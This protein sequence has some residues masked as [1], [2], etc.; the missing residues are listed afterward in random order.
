MDIEAGVDVNVFLESQKALM[1][2]DLKKMVLVMQDLWE[3][4]LWKQL[5][6][7]LM[8]FFENPE[9]EIFR[10]D[11]FKFFVIS[12]SQN[13]NKLKLVMLGLSASGQCESNIEAIK[14]L[15]SLL[16]NVNT[17]TTK[18]AYVYA[19]IEIARIKMLCGDLDSCYELLSK[20]SKILDELDSV[21]PIIYALFYRVN[22]D[23][24]KS[25][26]NYGLFYKNS[27][28]FLACNDFSSLSIHEQQQWA[29]DL[30]I[31]ALLGDTIY[32]FG[33]LLL[34]PI[35][36]TL[37]DTEH[38]WLR[39][40]LFAFNS[41]N[42]LKF[43]SL[44][45]HFLKHS[46]L[47]SSIPFLRQKI[48]LT[49]LIEAIFRRSPHDRILKFST[50]ADE[51]HLP[52]Y[53]IEH[54]V[55][56]AL[57]LDLIRGFI[58]QVDEIVRITW[59]HPRVLDRSQ[60][61]IMKKRI[62]DWHRS[63]HQLETFITDV[64][65]DIIENE[66]L[67]CNYRYFFILENLSKYMYGCD[68][69]WQ[70]LASSS[71]NSI[72]KAY[73]LAV[74]TIHFHKIF[75]GKC[76][77]SLYKIF[78]KCFVCHDVLKRSLL[79]LQCSHIGCW[80]K[81]HADVHA[82]NQNHNFAI[83]LYSGYLYCFSCHDFIYDQVFENIYI[84]VK[85]KLNISFLNIRNSIYLSNEELELSM[86]DQDYLDEDDPQVIC[87]GDG[88]RG[89]Q[90]MGAT[91]FMNV[92]IQCLV[93]NPIFRNYF[94]SDGHMVK[95]CLQDNCSCCAM[96]T[97][98]AEF[99][100]KK[101][102]SIPFGPSSFLEIMWKLSKELKGYAEQDAHE[103]FVCL[104]SQIHNHS[105]SKIDLTCNCV[106]HKTFSGILQSDVTCSSCGNITS[107][108]DP[109]MDVSLE[110]KIK[111]TVGAESSSSEHLVGS[112]QECLQRFTSPEK[113]SNNE[114]KCS[115]CLSIS[116]KAMK[117]LRFKRIPLVICFQL[118]RFEHSST[119]TKIDAHVDFSFQLD[120]F[121]YIAR[122][123]YVNYY[124]NDFIYD[125][126]CVVCHQGQI[127]TG[128][129]TSFARAND[130]WFQFDDTTILITNEK[131]VL[132]SN[133]YLLFYIRQNLSY[134]M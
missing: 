97:V 81:K 125:L 7:T 120:M 119:P 28:L 79:C 33:E 2:D 85:R 90:N 105:G 59:V 18:D 63:T 6:D 29:Y 112:L 15:S 91:C 77:K 98:I 88:L 36:D 126:L 54:L 89:I 3:R 41:G 68:H 22:A 128:H 104:M 103:F 50:I 25:K 84:L 10:M 99:F 20:S 86:E 39:Q 100:S 114:Y 110:L 5:T 34:H 57:S 1:K 46:L 30:S 53:E 129:Y 47:Q 43:E 35:L 124:K 37:S 67:V 133:A 27:L 56:K 109:I 21:D 102:F 12:F 44:M 38:E 93:H 69:V 8:E 75:K 65:S 122:N 117:Q 70:L 111:C 55:M 19:L 127:N 131:T 64:G 31:A 48:C 78:Q 60:I 107:T 115:K 45:G 4:R 62:E 49:A 9:S 51:T 80:R 108:M 16:D 52:E 24:Y 83:D 94:L 14:F 82:R 116:E 76:Y 132:A 130:N 13:I 101:D 32:N 11:M 58:D 61:D 72:C 121:P 26:A 23:Y 96:D 134:Q 71:K 42:I 87:C 118:K 95:N 113:L 74:K 17:P 40:L 106:A 92:V 73:S 66:V 123:D